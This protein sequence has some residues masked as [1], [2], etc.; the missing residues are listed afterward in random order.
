[1]KKKKL[2][3]MMLKEAESK[4]EKVSIQPNHLLYVS[5][6]HNLCSLFAIGKHRLCIDMCKAFI[7]DLDKQTS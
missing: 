7:K 6:Y 1:M 2:A 5:I 3:S 4:L